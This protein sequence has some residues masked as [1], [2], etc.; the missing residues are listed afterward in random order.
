MTTQ[1]IETYF[2]LLRQ[3]IGLA[4][5]DAQSTDSVHDARCT[6]HDEDLEAV[7]RLAQQQGTGPLVFDQI[8][9]VPDSQCTMHDDLR[10]QMKQVCIQ[11]MVAQQKLLQILK[12]TFSALEKGGVQPALLKG[13]GLASLYPKPYLRTWGDLDVYVGPGQYHE[14]AAILRKTFPEAKH[15]DEE[16]EELK[17][18]NFVLPD[19]LVEMHRT[20][21]KLDHPKDIRV[22]YAL[23]NRAMTSNVLQQIEVE[24]VQ[25]YLPEAKFNMLFTFL[26]AVYHF[27]GE[28]LGMK[29]LADLCLLAHNTYAKMQAKGELKAYEKYMRKYLRALRIDELW[30]LF[31][32]ICVHYLG[33][34]KAEWVC[35]HETRW[36]RKH[37][38]KLLA[39]VLEEGLCRETRTMSRE[40][41]HKIRDQ[42]NV[43]Y[44]KW[45]TFIGR[46][47]DVRFVWAHSP[48]YAWHLL[49]TILWKGI[50][51]I[52]KN[53]AVI[54]Y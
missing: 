27:V 1:I 21:V 52:I 31:G 14:A 2:Q 48:Q 11:N 12:T 6:V 28:G 43:V 26:H 16:Y 20:T 3:A 25:V 44:R 19:G 50:R 36:V 47:K 39:H 38:E 37:G 42:W 33:L 8:L 7:V 40:E 35:Y 17:H 29:L 23:E 22:Y 34:P 5:H 10:M 4:V 24:G 41:F 18:Y 46:T 32:Y 53:E 45:R 30:Q 49:M 9:S 51:R 54:P 13:F 15:H